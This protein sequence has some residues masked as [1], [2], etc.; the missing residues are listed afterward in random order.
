MLD[1]WHRILLEDVPE[2]KPGIRRAAIEETAAAFGHYYI[3]GEQVDAAVDY[4]ISKFSEMIPDACQSSVDT[5]PTA[6]EVVTV[7]KWAAWAL[8]VLLAIH[9]YFDGNG[10]LCRLLCNYV[11]SSIFPFDIPVFNVYSTCTSRFDYV[12]ALIISQNCPCST[13]TTEMDD[14]ENLCLNGPDVFEQ[15]KPGIMAT[16]V[17][18]SVCFSCKHFYEG[19]INRVLLF[20]SVFGLFD[21]DGLLKNLMGQR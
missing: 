7:V 16:M 1:K 3:S 8:V 5:S 12:R 15:A 11:L 10:R 13:A 6:A 17:L 19:K 20:F 2:A 14:D 21:W 4:F 9:P 18:E